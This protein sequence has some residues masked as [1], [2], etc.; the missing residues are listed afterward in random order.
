MHKDK[1]HLYM[2]RNLFGTC[3]V[4]IVSFLF[5]LINFYQCEMSEALRRLFV[6]DIYTTLYFVLL[7]L[8][9]YLIFEISKII[10][11]EYER[12]VTFVPCLFLIVFSVMIFFIPIHS[13]FRYNIC[14]LS[15]LIVMRMVKQM[16]KHSPELFFWKQKK[17]N[18]GLK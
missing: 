2:F 11:D 6:Y 16:Y 10:Y 8:C 18:D 15:L 3:F 5:S 4:A 12:K 13:L 1:I 7:W 14:L 9:D 17:T